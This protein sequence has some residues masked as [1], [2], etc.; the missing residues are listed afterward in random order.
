MLY[1]IDRNK[2]VTSK[3]LYQSI[4]LS[5]SNN[6]TLCP[7]FKNFTSGESTEALSAKMYSTQVQVLV[8]I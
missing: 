7:S 3:V 5:K 4:S 8:Q 2:T 6:T 1:R